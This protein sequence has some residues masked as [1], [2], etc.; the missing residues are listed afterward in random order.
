MDILGKRAAGAAMGF[1]GILSY[2]GSAL[3]EWI[4]GRL[5]QRGLTTETINTI[6]AQGQA[7]ATTVKH[8]DFSAAISFWI[9]ASVLS[10][11]LAATLWRVKTKE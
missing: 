10:V 2:L 5:I 6:N 1:I 7:V 11:I 9:G 4:S 3:Q 8:Y